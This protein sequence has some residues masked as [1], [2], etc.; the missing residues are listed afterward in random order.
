MKQLDN[1]MIIAAAG[2]VVQENPFTLRGCAQRTCVPV[3][4]S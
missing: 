3:T 1:L 4:E 2:A